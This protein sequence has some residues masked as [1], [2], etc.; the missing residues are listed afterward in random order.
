MREKDSLI[1]LSDVSIYIKDTLHVNTIEHI[2]FT[3]YDFIVIVTINLIIYY[4]NIKISGI[5]KSPKT[6]II[7][8]SDLIYNKFD[9]ISAKNDLKLIW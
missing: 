4:T 7:R 8:F 6:D 9:N 3:K 2:C 5:Y 1:F